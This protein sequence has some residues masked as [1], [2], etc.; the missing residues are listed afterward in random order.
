MRVTGGSQDG[1]PRGAAQVLSGAR[2]QDGAS[3]A[4]FVA[5]AS[6]RLLHAAEL[7]TGNPHDAQDLVQVVLE[8]MYL[9]WDRVVPDDPVGYARRALRNERTDRWRRSRGR[10]VLSDELPDGADH[11][12]ALDALGDREDVLA[13]LGLLTPRQR[14]VVF[15][16]YGEDLSEEQ[17][18]RLLGISVGTVK[19]TASRALGRLRSSPTPDAADRRRPA[20]GAEERRHETVVSAQA[21]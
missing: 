11:D 14:A 19:S 15:L 2:D 4:D 7:L 3:Y 13:L 1:S 5:R 8:R 16:R 21:T 18:A 17:T 10:E 9:R 12:T 20:A 6:P